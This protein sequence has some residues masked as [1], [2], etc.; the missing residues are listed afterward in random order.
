MTEKN[1]ELEKIRDKQ[2]EKLEILKNSSSTDNQTSSV[3]QQ[4]IN[5]EE[6]V[7]IARKDKLFFEDQWEK[8]VDKIHNSNFEYHQAIESQIKSSKKELNNT[9]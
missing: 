1:C 4:L 6:K 3:L 8:D 2:A 5:L 7:D 9:E